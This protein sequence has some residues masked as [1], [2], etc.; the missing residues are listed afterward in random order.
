MDSMGHRPANVIFAVEPARGEGD[1]AFRDDLRD[2]DNAAAD[3]AARVAS[4]VETE[5]DF[6]EL[7]VEGNRDGSEKLC[8]AESEA[9]EAYVR[10]SSERIEFRAG[11]YVFLQDGSIHLVAEHE[12]IAPF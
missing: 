7:G 3:F 4:H 6:F 8:A 12:E 1:G 9:D 10:F 11:G 2:E 5:I